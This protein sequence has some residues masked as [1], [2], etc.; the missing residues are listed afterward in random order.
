MIAHAPLC[1][2]RS[3]LGASPSAAASL[4]RVQNPEERCR[5]ILPPLPLSRA[6]F[7]WSEQNDA[8]VLHPSHPRRTFGRGRRR[9][10]KLS[11]VSSR[12]TPDVL[13]GS[14][15]DRELGFSHP[16]GATT[17][18]SR[19]S[20]RTPRVQ[21]VASARRDTKAISISNHN[22]PQ[23]RIHSNRTSLT[24]MRGDL[25]SDHSIE[26]QLLRPTGPSAGCVSASHE[27]ARRQ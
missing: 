22:L 26:L 4:A 18:A 25:Y 12:P 20:M 7:L 2:G 27:V 13:G 15:T 23:P 8:N 10:C 24:D 5:S 16:N 9:M 1:G 6:T 3:R 11:G 14:D 19:D 21:K 17:L